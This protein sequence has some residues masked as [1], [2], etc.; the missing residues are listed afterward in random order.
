MYDIILY[1][2]R[3]ILRLKN[4]ISDD[5]VLVI[6]TDK[7]FGLKNTEFAAKKKIR[8]LGNVEEGS[9]SVIVFSE[10]DAVSV[11]Y[12]GT[13]AKHYQILFAETSSVAF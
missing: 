7:G 1:Y 12:C 13:T 4:A 2:I 6:F 5:D 3:R 10:G 9:R 11:A 8:F